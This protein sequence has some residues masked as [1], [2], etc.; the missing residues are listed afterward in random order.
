MWKCDNL[1][2]VHG[3]SG[4][5]FRVI[6]GTGARALRGRDLGSFLPTAAGAVTTQALAHTR[7]FSGKSNELVS[8]LRHGNST[9]GCR[10]VCTGPLSVKLPGNSCHSFAD[11]LWFSRWS[12]DTAGTWGVS[13]W[14][15]EP[16]LSSF[17]SCLV[18]KFGL[19]S[20][21][22]EPKP[23]PEPEPEPH[24]THRTVL[25]F[26]LSPQSVCADLAEARR[27]CRA[28]TNPTSPLLRT[29]APLPL[30][31]PGVT[32]LPR[33]LPFSNLLSDLP[34]L[35]YLSEPLADLEPTLGRACVEQHPRA[36]EYPGAASACRAVP[37]GQDG[38]QLLP[39]HETPPASQRQ[40][41]LPAPGSAHLHPQKFL[42][43]DSVPCNLA[44]DWGDPRPPHQL[45]FC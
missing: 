43:W 38:F 17:L 29:S 40:F 2:A 27:T 4:S 24:Q 30:P 8:P 11:S 10:T 31:Q 12:G 42:H 39:R 14:L 20:S 32:R 1:S 15:F 44:S 25:D 26:A 23:E 7:G 37:R 21:W 36:A 3:P 13:L 16:C 6:C 18:N 5:R 22:K 19:F 28:T 45:A 34:D 33:P 41:S 35:S 9:T